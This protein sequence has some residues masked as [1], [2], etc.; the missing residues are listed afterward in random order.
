M[1]REEWQRVKEVLHQAGIAGGGAR[2]VPGP[3]VRRQRRTAHRSGIA[4]GSTAPK[5]S[6]NPLAIAK[7]ALMPDSLGI[8][9]QSGAVPYRAVDAEGGMGAVYQA[10]RVDDCIEGRRHQG[11]PPRRRQRLRAQAISIP[12]G[13]SW[14]TW[15][16]PISPSCWTAAPRPTARPYFVMDF[17][18]GTPIDHYCDCAQAHSAASASN[19]SSR[20]APRCTTRTRTW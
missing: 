4:D 17:I 20:S 12:N 13:R 9:A 15:I 2:R 1:N 16:I 10:V 18:A 5:V 11:D 6:K 8:G 19:S 14:R 3:R 7:L